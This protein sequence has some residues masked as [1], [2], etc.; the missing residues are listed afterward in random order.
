MTSVMSQP[1]FGLTAPS[2]RQDIVSALLNDYGTSFGDDEELP[3][4]HSP[5]S[6]TK[7][8]PPPPPPR[9]DSLRN[10]PLPAVQR[11]S[12]KFPLR[13][14]PTLQDYSKILASSNWLPS[15]LPEPK[16]SLFCVC[17]TFT[18]AHCMEG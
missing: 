5:T 17:C 16:P 4:S 12:M 7:K 2:S 14:K 1:G 9:G 18:A 15:T 8:L 10:K 13:G 6:I 11:M 3:F